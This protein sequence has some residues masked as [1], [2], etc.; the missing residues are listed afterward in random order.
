MPKNH[1]K[2]GIYSKYLTVLRT[3][4]FKK[5]C[6]ILRSLRSKCD[7]DAFCF[8]MIFYIINNKV[9]NLKHHSYPF[10]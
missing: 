4:D 6:S 10:C 8:P 7:F 2:K 1:Y 5:A 9:N 3:K